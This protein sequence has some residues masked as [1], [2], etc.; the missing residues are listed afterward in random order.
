[1]NRA[2][3]AEAAQWPRSKIVEGNIGVLV[4]L[5]TI[6]AKINVFDAEA[7]RLRV[8]YLIET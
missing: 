7:S 5:I 2:D 4:W 1:M 8:H 3:E 6:Y